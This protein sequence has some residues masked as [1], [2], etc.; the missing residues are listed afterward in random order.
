M[1]WFIICALFVAVALLSA[2]AHA[3]DCDQAK[4]PEDSDFKNFFRSV[5]CKV[6]QGAEEAAI[7]VK[8][9][10]D[11]IGDG[12]KE[13]GSSVANKFDELKHKFT[14]EGTTAKAPTVMPFNAPTERVPLAPI[15][16]AVPTELLASTQPMAG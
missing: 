7:V 1:K 6:K 12:A 5:S 4:N 9:Y 10:T 3:A 11:K 8:P 16:P 2:R 13:I 14:D 15:A